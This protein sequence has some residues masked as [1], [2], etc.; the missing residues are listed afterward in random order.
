[1]VDAESIV[2]ATFDALARDGKYRAEA[3][4]EAFRRYKINDPQAVGHVKQE[5][6]GA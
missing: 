3:P 1:M 6:A 5:G 4:A 2:L